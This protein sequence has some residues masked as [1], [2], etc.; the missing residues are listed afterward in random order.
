MLIKDICKDNSLYNEYMLPKRATK[1][2]CGKYDYLVFSGGD[3]SFHLVINALADLDNKPILG[4]IPSGTCNDIA[5]N[6]RLPSY[7]I[8]KCLDI[9][10]NNNYI[11]HDI[12]KVNDS[13]CM[14]VAA[15]GDL[16]ELSFD[17]E[18]NLKKVFGRIAYY[19]SGAKRVFKQQYTHQIKLEVDG[20]P[21]EYETSL[22]LVVN[23]K[24]IASF[25]FNSNGYHNDGK[26]DVIIVNYCTP[27][28]IA[29]CCEKPPKKFGFR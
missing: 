9:I 29:D 18:H 13:Y 3:G 19:F 15:L 23:S 17:T 11:E 7:S 16:A 12:M 1:N 27:S 24:Y 10:L 5:A 2:S 21:F 8:S 25:K 20:V 6:L 22:C 26:V 4:Y 28:V 14:Y